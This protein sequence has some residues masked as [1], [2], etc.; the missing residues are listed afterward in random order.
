MEIMDIADAELE[1]HKRGN[2]KHIRPSVICKTAM[3]P[4][5]REA[6]ANNVNNKR[7]T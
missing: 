4:H 3:H 2:K 1:V 6:I 5:R 7:L